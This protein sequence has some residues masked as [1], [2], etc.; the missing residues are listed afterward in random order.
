MIDISTVTPEERKII[1][2]RRA[3]QRIWRA[4]HK[5]RIQEHNR[6]FYEK[7]AKENAEKNET[8]A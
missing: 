2:A 1:E 7:K 5:D 4:A 8:R 6:R 3:Y